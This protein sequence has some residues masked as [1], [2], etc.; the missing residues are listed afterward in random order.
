[1]RLAT[2]VSSLFARSPVPVYEKELAFPCCQDDHDKDHEE[3]K[4]DVE[5]LNQEAKQT[6]AALTQSADSPIKKQCDETM[7]LS[8][9]EKT[10]CS[11]SY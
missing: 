5:K 10:S 3:I 8:I 11:S 2:H 7:D 9:V 6:T 1:M 4:I